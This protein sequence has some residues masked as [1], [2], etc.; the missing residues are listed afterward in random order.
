M[1]ESKIEKDLLKVLSQIGESRS[2]AEG[3]LELELKFNPNAKSL[4]VNAKLLEFQRRINVI[5]NILSKWTNKSQ[6]IMS[7]LTNL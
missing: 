3:P 4:Y 6:P 7:L 1:Y 5:E 2:A